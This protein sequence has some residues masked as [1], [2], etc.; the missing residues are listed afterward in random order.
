MMFTGWDRTPLF[1][2]LLRLS[3]WA[4]GVIHTSLS[5]FQ[6]LYFTIAYDW[7][8]FGHDLKDRMSKGEEIFFFCFFFLK[9]IHDEEFSVHSREHKSRNSVLN[10]DSDSQLRDEDFSTFT[11]N[12]KNRHSVL[13]NDSDSQLD[14]VMFDGESVVA[15]STVSSNLSL[16][17]WC[18]S[19]SQH[20][21]DSQD[22]NPPSVF[23]CNSQESQD[24]T[25]SNG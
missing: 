8:L 20:S 2:S 11:P 14:N 12:I 7:M 5:A 13:R 9:H 25:H 21:R 3:L 16:N 23:H 17:S 6:I 19:V 18:S 1:V 4:D 10:H 15:L 22:N 24:D